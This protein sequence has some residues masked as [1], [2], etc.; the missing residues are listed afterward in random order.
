MDRTLVV[1]PADAVAHGLP[2]VQIVVDLSDLPMMARTFIN[3]RTYA[4]LVGPPGGILFF[5]FL[6]V[7]RA[8][9]TGDKLKSLI[10]EIY[11]EEKNLILRTPDSL[12]V[13]GEECQSLL[14]F[15]GT[16]MAACANCALIVE[17]PRNGASAP[18]LL[19]VFGHS[20]TPE[21]VE[22]CLQIA[23]H[24][25]LGAILETMKLDLAVD[26]NAPVELTE[27]LDAN[28][29]DDDDD[30]EEEFD[31]DDE[32]EDEDACDEDE[33]DEDDDVAPQRECV[34]P[35]GVSSKVLFNYMEELRDTLKRMNCWS[36]GTPSSEEYMAW[37]PLHQQMWSLQAGL[38]SMDGMIRSMAARTPDEPIYGIVEALGNLKQLVA[39][40]SETED[41]LKLL[42]RGPKVC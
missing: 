20:G 15:T 11:T 38:Q 27:P 40:S 35:Q 28:S 14:F 9:D 37:T 41:L 22:D 23:S 26:P 6:S 4:A 19:L 36:E 30:D 18:G 24:P 39:S 42:E 32:H 33:N 17:P 12:D 13:Q 5:R 1:A 29:E 16:S 25:T 7:P 34:M 21:Q 3:A 2:P 10:R 31:E 8:I